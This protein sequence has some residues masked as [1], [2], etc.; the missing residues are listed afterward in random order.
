MALSTPIEEIVT[1]KVG[2]LG[3]QNGLRSTLSG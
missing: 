3:S 2:E 1:Q